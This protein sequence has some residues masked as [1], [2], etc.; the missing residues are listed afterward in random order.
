MWVYEYTLE[1]LRVPDSTKPLHYRQKDVNSM[2][3]ACA[4]AIA[5][6]ASWLPA[7]PFDV[8]KT[9]MMTEVNPKRFRSVW[10]CF[11]VVKQVYFC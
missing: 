2:H 6:M 5:G 7:I 3:T 11:Q 10:H 9:R 1:K 4:G 8:V